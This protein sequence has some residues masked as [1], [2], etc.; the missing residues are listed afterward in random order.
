MA[1]TDIPSDKNEISLK[2][3]V[4]GNVPPGSYTITLRGDA[5]AAFNRDP[6]AANK[7]NVRVADPSTPMTVV[8]TAPTKK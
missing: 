3:A 4:A 8:V 2:F 6:K 1:T 7:P 5:Q